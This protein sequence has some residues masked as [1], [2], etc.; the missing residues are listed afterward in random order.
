MTPESKGAKS[1]Q[2]K[3]FIRV[4]M[5]PMVDLG[6]LLITFF[7]FTTQF[8]KPNVMDLGLPA[9]SPT[10]PTNVIDYRNQITFVLGKDNRIFY[11]QKEL[12][13]LSKSDFHETSLQGLEV[14]KTIQKF[15]K[16]ALNPDIFTVIIKPT[17]D[18]NYKNFVDIMDEMAISKHEIYGI[19]DLKPKEEQLY[20]ELLQ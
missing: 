16:S 20:K 15:K 6:F 3:K 10:P 9:K 13:D 8:T 5:T 17:D 11:Y 2:K 18:S 4:D 14:A 19:T 12:Q 7:M 1:P